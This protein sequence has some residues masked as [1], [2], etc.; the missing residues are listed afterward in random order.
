MELMEVIFSCCISRKNAKSKGQKEKS[1]FQGGACHAPLRV[2]SAE[3]N[4]NKDEQP[5]NIIDLTNVN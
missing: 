3:R 5:I 2:S 1:I 4:K